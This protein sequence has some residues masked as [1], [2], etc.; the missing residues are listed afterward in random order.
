MIMKNANR[1]KG[2]TLAVATVFVI[3]SMTLY[4]L[5]LRPIAAGWVDEW[6]DQKTATSPGYYEG[7]KRGYYSAGNFSGH[8]KLNTD[9]VVTVM[10]PK[11]KS[12]CGGIDA[13]WGG[14]GFL[15]FDYLVQKGQRILQSAPYASFDIALNTLCTPCAQTIKSV[16][17]I[18]NQLNSIQL[19]DCKA[20]K[21]IAT[22][23]LG[24]FTDD[25]SKQD[26][27]SKARSDFSQSTGLDNLYANIKRHSDS[28]GKTWS[29]SSTKFQTSTDSPVSKC[30]DIVKN[31]LVQ[32]GSL[33]QKVGSNVGLS[34]DLISMARGLI[35]DVYTN[36]TNG[37]T[38]VPYPHCPQN[39]PDKAIDITSTGELSVRNMSG[40]VP[41]S[42]CQP[43][44]GTTMKQMVG[45]WIQEI[46]TAM[47][48]KTVLST[49][50]ENF[51]N[52]TPLSLGM[53]L[54]AAV[55][56]GVESEA[57]ASL[58]DLVAKS[59][60]Y[61]MLSDM[62]SHIEYAITKAEQQVA[63]Q[64]TGASTPEECMIELTDTSRLALNQIKE[65]CRKYME[66]L[67][68]QL[69]NLLKERETLQKWVDTQANFSLLAHQEIKKRFGPGV[70]N[71]AMG[72][73]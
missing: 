65:N 53:V 25:E 64:K 50:D 46:I 30:P 66:N 72:A 23:P 26:R 69:N 13:F 60:T 39:N 61:L 5:S 44:S 57:A 62:F 63:A 38:L 42:A 32:E 40:N 48:N 12:G 27:L 29:E 51:L 3:V 15:N 31:L 4:P 56:M 17:A 55:M 6:F 43:Y 67:Q 11:L 33:L 71:R 37:I 22:Y 8:V 9:P 24:L 47:K 54:K 10:P 35:G 16:E 36:D 14:F 19:D 58:P 52:N 21:A 2:K 34:G 28:I 41:S 49:E 1:K 73:Q 70:A 59:Y 7:E 18:A 20:A 45:T 68:L